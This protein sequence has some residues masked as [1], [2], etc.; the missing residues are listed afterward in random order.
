MHYTIWSPRGSAKIT[1]SFQMFECR[2]IFINMFSVNE[3][4]KAKRLWA[5]KGKIE[6]EKKK[7]KEA[8][9]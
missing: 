9:W 3:G 4:E 1:S 6:Q 8:H 7:E 2:V 5:R